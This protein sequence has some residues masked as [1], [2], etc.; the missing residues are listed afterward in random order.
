MERHELIAWIRDE[1][2]STTVIECQEI[3]GYEKY[4]E[5]NPEMYCSEFTDYPTTRDRQCIIVEKPV[6]GTVSRTVLDLTRA[7]G[8]AETLVALILADERYIYLAEELMRDRT[9]FSKY[10]EHLCL[11]CNDKKTIGIALRHAGRTPSRLFVKKLGKTLAKPK[12]PL[13][14]VG[15]CF[16]AACVYGTIIYFIWPNSKLALRIGRTIKN[17]LAESRKILYG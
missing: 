10:W 8:A 5:P 15:K 13:E 2:T 14:Y 17:I 4:L 7:S 6:Y 11:Y 1:I 9:A 3:V 12:S 16:V